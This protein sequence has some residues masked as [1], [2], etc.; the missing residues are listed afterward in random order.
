MSAV[1]GWVD[2]SFRVSA[3]TRKR[4]FELAFAALYR[5]R[6]TGEETVSSFMGTLTLHAI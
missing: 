1:G 3:R 6:D 2:V 4:A 5:A